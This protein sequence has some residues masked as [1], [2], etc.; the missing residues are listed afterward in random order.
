M[1]I[2]LSIDKQQ[3][4]KVFEKKLSKTELE[5]NLIKLPAADFKDEV[6][7]GYIKIKVLNRISNVHIDKCGRIFC[8]MVV[9]GPLDLDNIGSKIVL[10]EIDN[11]VYELTTG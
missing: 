8:G 3:T 7:K 10:R 2:F 6:K 4:K 1:V 5:R 11:S 9:F